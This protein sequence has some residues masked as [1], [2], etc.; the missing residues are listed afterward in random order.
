MD[1]E[2]KQPDHDKFITTNYFYKFSVAVFDKRLKKLVQ[3]LIL[4]LLNN[5]LSKMRKYSKITNI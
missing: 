2:K 5:V 4:I 3:L 1:I